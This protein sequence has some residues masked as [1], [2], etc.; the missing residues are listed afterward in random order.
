MIEDV[1]LEQ[2]R[3]ET[4]EI[5]DQPEIDRRAQEILD[6]QGPEAC[7]EFLTESSNENALSVLDDWWNLADRLVVKYSNGMINDFE[8]DTTVLGGIRTGGITIPGTS[9]DRG[10]IRSRSCGRSKGSF[11]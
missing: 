4:E 8:N 6:D 7:R 10:Y 11:T 3:I 9:T 5:R 2:R 1:Q